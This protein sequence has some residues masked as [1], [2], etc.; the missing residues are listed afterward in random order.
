MFADGQLR[1]DEVFPLRLSDQY[2]SPDLGPPPVA[3]F[4]C[5]EPIKF[6]ARMQTQAQVGDTTEVEDIPADLAVN[7]ETRKRRRDIGGKVNGRRSSI[8]AD[9]AEETE[10]VRS[11]KAS[12]KRDASASDG[13]VATTAGVKDFTFS[14]KTANGNNVL[15][16]DEDA[17]TLEAKSTETV[18]SRVVNVGHA[19]LEV[20]KRRVLGNSTLF[21]YMNTGQRY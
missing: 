17:A 20:A 12:A 18:D 14:R 7:L 5:D 19:P 9:S 15:G 8:F 2:E 6:D 16:G 10:P 1:P 11:L 3:H 13:D 4:E 21:A